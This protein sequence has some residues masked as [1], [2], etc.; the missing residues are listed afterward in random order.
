[1]IKTFIFGLI[2]GTLVALLLSTFNLTFFGWLGMALGFAIKG[3]GAFTNIAL[4]V[5]LNLVFYFFIS[6]KE[7]KR[8]PI[9]F[10]F[11]LILG[12]ILS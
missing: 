10:I 5:I 6:Q 3:A 7:L 1:M 9:W 11:G 2:Q 12:V 8:N 4:F